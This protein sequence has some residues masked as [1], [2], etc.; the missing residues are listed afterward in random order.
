MGLHL[1][2]VVVDSGHLQRCRDVIAQHAQ[3]SEG[4]VRLP[5]IDIAD[6]KYTKYMLTTVT[7]DRGWH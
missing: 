7:T 3:L 6:P 4:I 1:V 2:E 5:V